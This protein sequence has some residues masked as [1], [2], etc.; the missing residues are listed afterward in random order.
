MLYVLEFPIIDLK[1][2]Y[3]VIEQSPPTVPEKMKNSAEYYL[4]SCEMIKSL[5]HSVWECKYH[6]VC[7]F[8]AYLVAW[9]HKKL[10]KKTKGPYNVSK[11]SLS[12][13]AYEK[14]K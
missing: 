11:Y 6:V 4:K 8:F 3:I 5:S 13:V 10:E 14:N 12:M 1:H 2:L 9:L 7:S